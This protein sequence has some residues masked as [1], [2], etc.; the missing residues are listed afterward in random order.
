VKALKHR[1]F[2]L[3]SVV[4]CMNLIFAISCKKE[5]S[6]PV[7]ETGTITDIENNIY[8]TVKIGNQWW[9]T[10]NLKVT[11][12]RNG[13]PI[14][15]LQSANDWINP[16]SAFCIYSDNNN[17]PGYL[18]NWYAVSDSNN[19]APVGWYIP[20]DDECKELEMY[21]GMSQKDADNLNWRGSEEGE[22]LKE[23]G[24]SNWTEFDGVWATNES[25][26]SALAGSCR[27]FNGKWGEPGLLSNGFW[28]TSSA[29]SKNEIWYRYLDY[30]EKRVFR[31]TAPKAYGFSIRC[32]KDR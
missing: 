28:W 3:V 19:I 5:N 17:S 26:F 24:K 31:S 12:F 6:E 22:K 9:M 2:L 25:G 14:P 8:K 16:E 27:L 21:L 11:M 30:K 1:I 4:L 18:Y 29:N 20:T 7:Q 23:K 15:K 13:I 32:I 10:E